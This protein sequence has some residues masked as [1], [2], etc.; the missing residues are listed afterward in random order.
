MNDKIARAFNDV[1]RVQIAAVQQHFIHVLTLNAWDETTGAKEIVS[2]DA[3]DL[4]NAMRIVDW[5]I[6]RGES[7]S[8]A[9]DINVLAACMPRPGACMQ[10]VL[11]NELVLDKRLEGAL[12]DAQRELTGVVGGEWAAYIDKPLTC[13]SSYQN[14][15]KAALE[16]ADRREETDGT[17]IEAPACIGELFAHLMIMISQ[18]MVHSFVH[19]H[20]GR[21][22]L[23][24]DAW[25]ISGAAMMHAAAITNA[26]AKSRVAPAPEN[27]VRRGSVSL[28]QISY[29][30][31]DAMEADLERGRYCRSVAASAALELGPTKLGEICRTIAS[32]YE[33]LSQWQIG[34]PLPP[35]T[36]PC[37][38]FE[39]V[40]SAYVSDDTG[41]STVN[42]R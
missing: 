16:R 27:A 26:C 6:A 28:P 9:S 12:L 38:D 13:R 15:L 37:V 14:W 11:A 32:Y 4:P 36:N 3:V 24:N 18:S 1:L 30:T 8:L 23:A 34:H 33:A 39:R 7:V 31:G 10:D 20:S 25:F 22:N 5:L 2:V 29:N 35:I 40:Y 21:L 41:S 42:G 17:P 19:W